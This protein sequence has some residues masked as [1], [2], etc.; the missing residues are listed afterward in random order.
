MK[1]RF[2]DV[3][4]DPEYRKLLLEEAIIGILF[5]DI[6]GRIMD[7][8]LEFQ[9]MVGYPKGEL[10][11]MMFQQVTYPD[12]MV[13]SLEVVDAMIQGK[14]ERVEFSKRYV[15][16]DNQIVWAKVIARV[17]RIDG[18]VDH[19]VTFVVPMCRHKEHKSCCRVVLDLFRA[20]AK[21]VSRVQ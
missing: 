15:T 6:D 8:N 20:M 5:V 21:K 4:E 12:D 17:K 16:R 18:K 10:Q 9:R 3:I 11:K 13:A 2:E 14:V 19:F 1:F 7:A